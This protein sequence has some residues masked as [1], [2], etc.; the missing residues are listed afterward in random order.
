MKKK[1]YTLVFIAI[2]V[3]ALSLII[4]SP[5]LAVGGGGGG[6]SGGSGGSSGGSSGS[7]SGGSAAFYSDLSCGTD[8]G[9][10]FTKNPGT[11]NATVTASRNNI[12]FDVD[13]Y[14]KDNYF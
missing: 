2:S 6:G 4:P 8:G 11:L 10:K 14:W 12:T 3:L 7:S 1:I 13:G 9:I 5:V